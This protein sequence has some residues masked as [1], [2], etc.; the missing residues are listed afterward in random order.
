MAANF[1][2]DAVDDKAAAERRAGCTMS[3][4]DQAM[5]RRPSLGSSLV[6]HGVPW[7]IRGQATKCLPTDVLPYGV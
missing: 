6:I 5:A 2:W 3:T 1:P 4:T 7:E